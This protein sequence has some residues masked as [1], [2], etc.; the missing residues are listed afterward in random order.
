MSFR[1]C[2]TR[3]LPRLRNCHETLTW[4]R[5]FTV[6]QLSICASSTK[7]SYGGNKGLETHAARDANCVASVMTTTM[8]TFR[9]QFRC[10]TACHDGE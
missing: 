10:R 8:Y 7:G 5:L 6:F 2:A 3:R 9:W 1:I 4:Y